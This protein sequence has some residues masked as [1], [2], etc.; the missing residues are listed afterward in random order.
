[1]PAMTTPPSSNRKSLGSQVLVELLSL[2]SNQGEMRAEMRVK[3]Q[4]H[5]SRL[6]ALEQRMDTMPQ[7]AVPQEPTP[8]RRQWSMSRFGEMAR[9][10]SGIA[11]LIP[12]GMIGGLASLLGATVWQ[13]LAP[14]LQRL[15]TWLS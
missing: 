7:R 15:L 9:A 12:W 2:A 10:L 1:M 11:R 8:A 4:W 13:W 6:T 14:L 3:H 5:A